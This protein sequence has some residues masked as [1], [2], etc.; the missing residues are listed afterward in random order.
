[1]SNWTQAKRTLDSMERGAEGI[2]PVGT[3]HLEALQQ[4]HQSYAIHFVLGCGMDGRAEA[5]AEPTDENIALTLSTCVRP[6]R[7][8]E[9]PAIRQHVDTY[10]MGLMSGT[11]AVRDVLH[12]RAES[13]ARDA[14]RFAEMGGE[15]E[16][17]APMYRVIADELRK[18]RAS[19]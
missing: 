17:W 6:P 16:R 11:D 19:L 10:R 13:Y 3:R 9:Y 2:P 15:N 14:V 5:N 12:D 18:I 7:P 1:M 8:D 4:R